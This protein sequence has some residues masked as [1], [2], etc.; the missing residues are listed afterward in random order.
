MMR[1]YVVLLAD[2]VMEYMFLMG[3]KRKS[4][5]FVR[6]GGYKMCDDTE[7]TEVK[8]ETNNLRAMGLTFAILR[9]VSSGLVIIC[10]H[11][12]HD[13]E[14]MGFAE[15]TPLDEE[16]QEMALLDSTAHQTNSSKHGGKSSKKHGH[17]HGSK[18][19]APEGHGAGWAELSETDGQPTASAPVT[20]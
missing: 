18:K 17:D 16:G 14:E 13:P 9:S 10:Y 12:S 15:A 20:L 5:A 7:V 8:T 2:C 11:L 3:M 19:I 1:S 6:Q 4:P